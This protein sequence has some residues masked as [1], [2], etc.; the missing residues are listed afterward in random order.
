[1]FHPTA[2]QSSFSAKDLSTIQQFYTEVLGLNVED[3]PM[4]CEITLPG[5]AKVAVYQSDKSTPATFTLLNFIVNDIDEAVDGLTAKG[6]TFERYD[7]FPQ[8]EKGI[9]RGLATH[10]GPDAAWFKDPEGN[11]LEVLQIVA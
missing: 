9:A 10:R 1:M 4:G 8:D 7:M 2:A 11:I 3:A 6:V 5:G